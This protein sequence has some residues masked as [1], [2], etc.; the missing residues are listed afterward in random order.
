MD[1]WWDRDI[2][3][4]QGYGLTECGPNNFAM[5]DGW[6]REKA[7]TVGTPAF[8]VDARV[9]DDGD[10]VEPGAVGELQLRSPHAAAGYLDSPAESAATFGDGWV[11]TGDLASVDADGYYRIEGRKTDMFV[12]G[13]ENVYPSEVEAVLTEADRIDEAVVVPVSDEQ[14]GEIGKAIVAGDDSLTLADVEAVCDGRLARY[15]IPT[16]LTVVDE[17][18]TAGP[19]K[20]DRQ[21]VAERY[22]ESAD[23]SDR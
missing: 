7:D 22:G 23:E 17:L 6:S 19:E 16:A 3:L 21:A 2:D 1:A 13:G 9:V 15:K 11:S 4:S 20:I 5:P 18:P 14:W 8:H 10:P 12:S